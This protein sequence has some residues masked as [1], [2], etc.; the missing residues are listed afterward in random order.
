MERMQPSAPS[1]LTWLGMTKTRDEIATLVRAAP[2]TP[3]AWRVETAPITYENALA[4]MEART[5]AIA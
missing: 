5:A 3:A 4:F 2:G 1:H